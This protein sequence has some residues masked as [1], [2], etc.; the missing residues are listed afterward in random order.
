M[1]NEAN[2]RAD[3]QTI[4]LQQE[5]DRRLLHYERDF[6][7]NLS[8]IASREKTLRESMLAYSERVRSITNARVVSESSKPEG[9]HLVIRAKHIPKHRELPKKRRPLSL[10]ELIGVNSK[11]NK[12]KK[13]PKSASRLSL[14]SLPNHLT[15]SHP[16]VKVSFVSASDLYDIVDYSLKHKEKRRNNAQVLPHSMKNNKDIGGEHGKM[17]DVATERD[18]QRQ[19]ERQMKR[20]T[21]QRVK[22]RT[23]PPL[24]MKDLV[25][26]E[27][28]KDTIANS[29]E[30]KIKNSNEKDLNETIKPANEQLLVDKVIP[31][32][33]QVPIQYSTNTQQ[34]RTDALK[35]RPN[36]AKRMQ[37]HE[38]ELVVIPEGDVLNYQPKRRLRDKAEQIKKAN[39]TAVVRRSLGKVA[40]KPDLEI[41]LESEAPPPIKNDLLDSDNEDYVT[42]NDIHGTQAGSNSPE[43]QENTILDSGNTTSSYCNS[44]PRNNPHKKT[45][46]QRRFKKLIF[47]R[48]VPEWYYQ[49]I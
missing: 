37:L 14:P 34:A 6:D 27:S 5:Y 24:E 38:P 21:E 7:I 23:L 4:R 10:D 20:Q 13:K 40:A 25:E 2:P 15:K 35:R 33:E 12:T 22:H 32:S 43:V 18:T 47:L 17:A 3:P 49:R 44:T 1:S 46:A 26:E 16:N 29:D 19:V 48:D 28:H 36:R 30:I 41:I 31:K 45:R 8:R 11:Q 9:E 42:N 39:A